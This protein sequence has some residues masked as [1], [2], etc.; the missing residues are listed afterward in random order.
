MTYDFRNRS[1][2]VVGEGL[3]YGKYGFT[4]AIHVPGDWRSC[5]LTYIKMK[6]L[7]LLV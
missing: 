4:S 7:A 5:K 2:R 3:R 1:C 6:I